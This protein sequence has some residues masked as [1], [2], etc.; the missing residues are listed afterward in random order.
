MKIIMEQWYLL[1][2]YPIK[3]K[4]KKIKGKCIV[5]LI[6][7]PRNITLYISHVL[8]KKFIFLLSGLIQYLKN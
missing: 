7:T 8:N 2:L 5:Q 4:K 3:K 1:K 6:V